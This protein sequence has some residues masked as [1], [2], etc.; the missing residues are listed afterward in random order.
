MKIAFGRP[1]Y[2][3]LVAFD[4]VTI[5]YRVLAM[6]MTLSSLPNKCFWKICMTRKLI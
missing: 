5:H 1:V 3:T 4:I 2:T 6:Y